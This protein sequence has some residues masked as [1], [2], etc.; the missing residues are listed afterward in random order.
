M[1]AAPTTAT[2]PASAV[3]LWSRLTAV[4]CDRFGWV[5]LALVTVAGF[6]RLALF[7]EFWLEN[8][9]AISPTLDSELYWQRAAAIA[10]GDWLG[11]EPFHIAPLYPYLLAVLRRLGGGLA[12][13]YLVQIACHLA[14][15]VIVA[16]AARRRFGEVAGCVGVALFLAASEPALYATR[17]LGATL[18]LLIAALL[19]WDWARL[20]EDESR[21]L[22]HF[23]R[24]GVW[25]GLLALA[26]PAAVA[27]VAI[28]AVWIAAA[29]ASARVR[30][31]RALAGT[32]G[33]VA[34]IGTATLHN[35][36]AS[37]EFIPLTTHAG[38]TLA[39]GNAPGSIGIF[40]P[41]ADTSGGVKDQARESA[42]AFQ[43]ATGRRG[44]W[45]EIDRFYRDRVLTWWRERPGDA[46]R[47]LARKLYWFLTSSDYDNVTA[48]SFE[49]E[50]GLQDS[51]VFVPLETP[52]LMGIVLLG[53]ALV[54]TRAR[55]FTPELSLTALPLAVCLVFMYSARYRIVA[56][57][58]FCGLAGLVAVGWRQLAWPRLAT[59]LLVLS[60]ALL[61]GL[62][63]VTGFGSVDF[64]RADF[65]KLLVDTYLTSGRAQSA[66]G[67]LDQAAAYF[68][69]AAEIDADRSEP[70][71]E[72]ALLSLERGAFTEAR[73]AAIAAA[74]R[75]PEDVRAHHVLYNAQVGAEDYRSAVTTLHVLEKLTPE[76]AGVQVALAWLYG[77]CPD[78][79]LRNVDRARGHA[80]AAERLAGREDPEVLMALAIAAALD[81]EFQ[82]STALAEAGAARARERGD[83]PSAQSELEAFVTH[84]RNRRSI[85][86][87]PRLF[88]V[89]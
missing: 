35:A 2:A 70:L 75:R 31:L 44:S 53:V 40:T 77:A 71:T 19:W 22:R 64:M 12:S 18:Q 3:R 17:V 80:R 85:T 67:E 29:P 24:V 60:P 76:D 49:R 74:R 89:R 16:N 5:V 78:P 25:I 50:F 59:G 39:A 79:T 46:A 51:R 69:R 4:C 66:A 1:H 84:L 61:L 36:L 9:F 15:A 54:R 47:L 45:G 43:K 23:A 27:L 73:G 56:L 68:R 41:L 33:A 34:C 7:Q 83:P 82:E 48:F 81:G 65:E 21:P 37:G 52:Y 10:A 14:T 28:Y 58:V 87:A 32:A 88:R 8:P 86:A 11:D 55:R 57:P 30:T 26:Y 42:L 20:S 72:L 38:I 62:N 6:A 63:A 13:L